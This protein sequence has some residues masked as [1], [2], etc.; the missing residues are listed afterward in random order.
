MTL[1]LCKV[2]VT[3]PSVHK[4]VLILERAGLIRRRPGLARSIELLVEPNILPTLQPIEPA[5]SSVQSY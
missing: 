3:A 4:M 1:T 2:G 5:E